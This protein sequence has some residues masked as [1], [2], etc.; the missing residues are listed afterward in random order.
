[1]NPQAQSTGASRI[2]LIGLLLVQLFVGY[3]R[4][5]RSTKPLSARMRAPFGSSHLPFQKGV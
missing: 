3:W 1:M 5:V 4:S 2:P